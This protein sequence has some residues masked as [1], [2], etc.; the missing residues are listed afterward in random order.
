LVVG[1]SKKLLVDLFKHKNAPA[2][3]PEHWLLPDG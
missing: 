2:M 3:L 1:K